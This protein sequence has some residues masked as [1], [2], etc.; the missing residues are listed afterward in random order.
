[1]LHLCRG[2]RARGGCERPRW[3]RTLRPAWSTGPLRAARKIEH[4]ETSNEE[5]GMSYIDDL[6]ARIETKKAKLKSIQDANLQRLAGVAYPETIE[7]ELR[8]QIAI[9][10]RLLAEHS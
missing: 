7:N 2:R 4:P 1:M 5:D 3:A 9:D 6:R 8:R 10:E